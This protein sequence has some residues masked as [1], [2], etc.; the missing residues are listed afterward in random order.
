MSNLPTP[1]PYGTRSPSPRPR[2]RRELAE[3]GDR[4]LVREAQAAA[5]IEVAQFEAQTKMRATADVGMFAAQEVVAL[6]DLAVEV[7]ERK[8]HAAPAVARILEIT[9]SSIARQVSEFGR[10]L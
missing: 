1:R 9:A 8:P 4:V 3:L 2:T 10:E 6:S 5:D 7:A